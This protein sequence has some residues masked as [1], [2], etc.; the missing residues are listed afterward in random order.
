M[1]RPFAVIGITFFLTLLMLSYVNEVVMIVIL[2]VACV[3]LVPF[4]I[5]K[6]IRKQAVF[7]TACLVVIAGCIMTL[8]ANEFTYKPAIFISGEKVAFTGSLTDLPVKENGRVYYVIKTDTVNGDRSTFKIRLSCPEPLDA[9]PYDTIAVNDATVYVLGENNEDS[10]K[11]FKTT[12]TFLGAYTSSDVITYPVVKKPL[13]FYI[14][15]IKMGLINKVNE[16]LPNEQG[17]LIIALLIGDKSL[18]SEK[19]LSDFRDI[20]ISHIVAISGLNL[21]VF[22]LLF[23]DVFERLRLNKNFV[24]ISSSVF[25]ILIMALAGFSPS[26][27]RAGIMLLVLLLGKII[28]QDADAL[29]SLGLS[30]LIITVF[31]PLGAGYIGLQLSFFATLGILL[32]QKRLFIPFE[33]LTNRIKQTTARHLMKFICETVAVTVAASVFTL[34]IMIIAF[35]RVAL[36]SIISNLLLVYISSLTMILGGI[37]ALFYGLPFL[38]F[39]SYPF[40]I[41]AG[42]LAKY[43]IRISGFLSEIPYASIS[44]NGNYI[45]LWLAGSL[46]L[47]ALALLIRSKNEKKNIRFSALLCLATLLIGVFSNS[48]FNRNITRITIADIGNASATLISKNRKAALIGCGGDEFAV[49]KIYE[50]LQDNNINAL[51]LLLIPRVAVTESESA[52]DILGVYNTHNIILPEMNYALKFIDKNYD[53]KISKNEIIEPWDGAKIAYLYTDDLSCA[54]VDISGTKILFIF[55]PGCDIGNIP[56]SWRNADI[57]ICRAKP[58]EGLDCIKFGT[59]VICAVENSALNEQTK[60]NNAGGSAYVTASRGNI[61]IETRGN[62]VYSIGRE[63]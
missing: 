44:V 5:I 41:A 1:P 21:S 8:V 9:E 39:I 59:V 56:E 4:L 28:N 35:E 29:N 2:C 48:V 34:P 49:N 57:L 22:L 20:G 15:S 43:I 53:Y 38:S 27:L 55:Y 11:Y 23:L 51:D 6:N 10:L 26:V 45:K 32:L 62:A 12:G 33:M 46:L 58:P 61:V 36:I 13:M 24:Y 50:A 18:L 30:V 42:M 60:I 19:T 31:N 52:I 16:L 14:I 37:A 47:I 7:P 63:I 54:Y 25:V 3:S 17:G 40:A